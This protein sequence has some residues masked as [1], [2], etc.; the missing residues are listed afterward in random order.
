MVVLTKKLIAEE[1]RLLLSGGF[2]S[3]RDREKDRQIMLAVA[4]AANE[5]L[6]VEAL[7]TTFNLENGSTIGGFLYAT[8]TNIPVKRGV[9][10][11]EARTAVAEM[12][13]MPMNLP[14][15][16]GIGSIYP[17][18]MPFNEFLPIP[19]GMINIWLR[20]KMVSP[21]HS[22]LYT[23]DSMKVT[24]FSDLFS[25]TPAEVDMKLAISDINKMGENEILPIPPE[26]KN[27]IIEIARARFEMPDTK[28]K[29]TDEPSP[30]NKD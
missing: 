7:N 25:S 4:D 10:Y 14:N 19:T 16:M 26:Y 12:P 1:I 5:L 23:F 20:N 3:I 9:N 8:Y 18:G 6:K 11:G 30:S 22:R 27:K 21:L 28:R 15:G 13:V 29:E 24:I 17:S 2:P